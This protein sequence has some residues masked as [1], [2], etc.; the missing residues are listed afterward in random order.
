MVVDIVDYC[1]LLLF[2]DNIAVQKLNLGAPCP[3]YDQLY[4]QEMNAP[5]VKKEE[6][7]NAVSLL[8]IFSDLKII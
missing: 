1:Y 4:A 5:D 2:A 6:K 7:E 8:S 3:R